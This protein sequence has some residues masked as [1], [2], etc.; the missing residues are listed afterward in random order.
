[1]NS[2]EDLKL[3]PKKVEAGNLFFGARQLPANGMHTFNPPQPH[4]IFMFA[5]RMQQFDTD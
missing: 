5:C 3:V 2:E 1:M 4:L